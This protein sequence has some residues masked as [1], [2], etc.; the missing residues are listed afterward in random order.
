MRISW[1]PYGGKMIH[2]LED[3]DQVSFTCNHGIVYDVIIFPKFLSLE[4][5]RLIYIWLI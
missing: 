1:A 3:D 5:D 2:S 4:F